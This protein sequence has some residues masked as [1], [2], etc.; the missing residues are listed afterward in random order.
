MSCRSYFKRLDF[1]HHSALPGL[2]YKYILRQPPVQ[3][4]PGSSISFTHLLIKSTLHVPGKG[5]PLRCLMAHFT[6]LKDKFRMSDYRV[7]NAPDTIVQ[8]TVETLY[9]Y[10]GDG[11]LYEYRTSTAPATNGS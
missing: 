8:Q 3:S 7:Y 1:R 10:T 6:G 5:R 11:P 9:Q 4:I 2:S